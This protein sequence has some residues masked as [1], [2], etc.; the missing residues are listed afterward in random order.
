MR[1]QLFAA[2]SLARGGEPVTLPRKKSLAL[3]SVLAC[4]AEPQSR[5]ALG[6][7]LWPSLGTARAKAALRSAL[8]ELQETLGE[9]C[10]I[11]TRQAMTC[12]PEADID[13]LE[14]RGALARAAVI[15]RGGNAIEMI[16][17]LEKAVA[18]YRGD[19]LQGFS[20]PGHDGFSEWQSAQA[21]SLRA[22]RWGALGRLVDL[23]AAAG[24]GERALTHAE[25][26]LAIAPLELSVHRRV[27]RLFLDRGDRPAALEQYARCVRVLAEHRREPDEETRALYDAARGDGR[28]AERREAR[29][30]PASTLPAATTPLVGRERDLAEVVS[31]LRGAHGRMVTITG[32][33][34]VGKTRLAT[35]AAEQLATD[36]AD[37]ARFVPLAAVTAPEHLALAVAEAV[38]PPRGSAPPPAVDPIEGMRALETLLV[39]DGF[40]H[41]LGA[42]SWI[43]ELLA[44]APGVRVLAT[45]RERLHLRGEWEVP[46]AGLPHV[47]AQ[48]GR[49]PAIELFMQS[50]TRAHPGFEAGEAEA[51]AVGRICELLGGIPLG[52]ELAAAWVRHYGVVEIARR[53]EGDL[54][55]LVAPRD[56]PASQRSLRA[57]FT[58]SWELLPPHEQDALRRLSVFNSPFSEEAARAITGVDGAALASLGM[59][60]LLQRVTSGRYGLHGLIRRFAREELAKH[61][62]D[63]RATEVRRRA[64]FVGLC[65][66]LS[67]DL[68][69]AH[70]ASLARRIDESDADVRAAFAGAVAERAWEDLDRALF[71][72]FTA[73]EIQGRHG[74]AESVME[75]TAR[76]LRAELSAAA[77][78]RA[79]LRRLL[80]RVLARKARAG[81]EHL[82]KTAVADTLA[83]SIALLRRTSATAD[84][85][86][87]LNTEGRLSAREG[88][89]VTA[90]A[91]FR[92]ALR[93]RRET[94]DR[95]G[96]AIGYNNLSVIACRDGDYA[97]AERLLQRALR[98]FRAVDDRRSTVAC[99]SSLGDLRFVEGDLDGAESALREG[100][101]MG[102]EAGDRFTLAMLHAYLGQTLLAAAKVEQAGACFDE[103]LT[104]GRG[105]GHEEVVATALLGLG[106]TARLRG[107]LDRAE[108]ALEESLGLWRKLGGKPKMAEAQAALGL[109]LQARRRTLEAR[110]ELFGALRRASDL[111]AI[112]LVLDVLTSVAEARVLGAGHAADLLRRVVSHPGAT[113]VTARRAERVLGS[114]G[115]LGAGAASSRRDGESLSDVVDAMLAGQG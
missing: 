2:P 87:A 113:R 115:S 90:R 45:S 12:H 60:F 76:A 58:R 114:L 89:L 31:R 37:G 53:I 91:R 10:V 9:G 3:L 59:K 64:Y 103:A 65:A 36:F 82:P 97:K 102:R 54:D 77:R 108:R 84:L 22:A 24:D 80:G 56:A 75:D 104:I 44:R 62:E 35:A 63:E 49:G 107:D 46:L 28:L 6:A 39:L 66:E 20:L 40:E 51:P 32:T 101:A 1:I 55:F 47:A 34:G 57:T 26:M 15:E 85:C 7:L 18:V 4:E 106:T 13:V 95:R 68:S 19:F 27:I 96:M 5:G 98:I 111:G 109:V 69:G 86:Y 16:D 48:G 61:A 79:V 41:L 100:L 105:A 29:A 72:F 25:R 88:D 71:G 52:I 42:A 30:H 11:T 70:A 112:P 17:E 73:L 81:L 67:A 78:G 38:R 93:L 99:L 14:M 43:A 74:L 110:D 94:G 33:G 92:E 21:S 23:C 83:E 8:W 50:A